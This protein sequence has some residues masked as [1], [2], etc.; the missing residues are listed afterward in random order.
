VD[1][2]TVQLRIASSVIKILSS[3]NSASISAILGKLR[4]NASW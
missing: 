1:I 3:A 4:P 2:I